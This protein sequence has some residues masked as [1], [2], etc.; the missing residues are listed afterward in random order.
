MTKEDRLHEIQDYVAYLDAVLANGTGDQD[1][2]EVVL[3][4]FSQGATTA[5]RW[6]MKGKIRPQQF[7]MGRRRGH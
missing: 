6:L 5:W 3:L 1:L 7:I 4:G 2:P